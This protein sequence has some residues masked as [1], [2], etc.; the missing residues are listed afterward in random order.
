MY[1]EKYLF[2]NKAIPENVILIGRSI[3]KIEIYFIQPR[4]DLSNVICDSIKLSNQTDN[5]INNY[6]WVDFA[7][8]SPTTRFIER[9]KINI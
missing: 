4:L 6:I 2:I 3:Y 9:I 7:P 5:S 1:G 8:L